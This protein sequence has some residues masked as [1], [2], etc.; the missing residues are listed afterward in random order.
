MINLMRNPTLSLLRISPERAT[1]LR[2]A[3]ALLCS[4]FQI[5][6]SRIQFTADDKGVHVVAKGVPPFM[7][8]RLD[9][10]ATAFSAGAV[11]S[12]CSDEE[13]KNI[14]E[15][16]NAPDTIT[17]E[18]ILSDLV[19]HG[20]ETTTTFFDDIEEA[21]GYSVGDDD[22]SRW[23]LLADDLPSGLSLQRFAGDPL[24]RRAVTEQLLTGLNS[25]CRE[26]LSVL[27]DVAVAVATHTDPNQQLWF[28]LG[29]GLRTYL[30]LSKSAAKTS[31]DSEILCFRLLGIL[32]K[33][34]LFKQ[35]AAAMPRIAE[36]LALRERFPNLEEPISFICEHLAMRRARGEE[37]YA[38]PPILLIGPSGIGKT[39][40]SYE[41]SRVVDAF[42][43]TINMASMT[44]GFVLSGT[45]RK[46]SQAAPG[47][48]VKAMMDSGR[49]PPIIVLD[50]IDKAGSSSHN[51]LGPLYHLLDPLLAR[52]FVDEFFGIEFDTSSI[53]WIAPAN[54]K[55]LI[56]DPLLDRF[57]CFDVPPPSRNQLDV[58]LENMYASIAGQIPFMPRTMPAAWKRNM[59]NASLREAQ[60]E[61]KRAIGRAALQQELG[62]GAEIDFE[63]SSLRPVPR[64]K[65]GF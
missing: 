25:S 65:M 17:H 41:I 15:S 12:S 5:P 43:H 6:G 29:S 64:R 24:V 33:K 62:T 28:D 8:E 45:D 26:A 54:E 3:V 47:A 56:P 57:Q 1:E 22:V 42:P 51:V 31:D 49:Q 44:H 40:I 27:L 52:A 9:E 14:A 35:R 11:D 63:S 50:E 36:V 58:I 59:E 61:L 19:A 23:R 53:T 46:W 18:A 30:T 2:T 55:H 39:Y 60:R 7:Q 4:E 21:T 37:G 20:D 48:V 10:I 38:V 32:F 16:H 34:H 13:Y